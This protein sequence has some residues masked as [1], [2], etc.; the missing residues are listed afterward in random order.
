VAGTTSLGTVRFRMKEESTTK[1]AFP[2]SVPAATKE[3]TFQ[4]KVT[5]GYT[6]SSPVTLPV[7]AR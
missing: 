4:V 3:V 6:S 1:L 7:G 2:T 5:D